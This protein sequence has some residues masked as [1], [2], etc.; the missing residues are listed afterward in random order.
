MYIFAM[1][2][3]ILCTVFYHLVSRSI[4]TGVNPLVTLT[5]TY[6]SAAAVCVL[7]LPAFPLSEGLRDSLKRVNWTSI[8]LAL[9]IVGIELGFLMAYRAGWNISYATLVANV[10]GTLILLPLGALLFKE[11][12][13]LQQFIGIVVC[14]VGLYLI[15]KK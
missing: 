2:L 1:L 10:G 14:M 9:A 4:P 3:A 15:N 8:L 6:L 12:L 7:F 5:I 13:S 11:R